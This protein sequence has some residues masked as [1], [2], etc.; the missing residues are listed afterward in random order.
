METANYDGGS[1]SV[2]RQTP[3]A[4]NRPHLFIREKDI[5][6]ATSNVQPNNMQKYYYLN[7]LGPIVYREP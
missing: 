2:K 6:L 3:M 1:G 5:D 7:F 4:P